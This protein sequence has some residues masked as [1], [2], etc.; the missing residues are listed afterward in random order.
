MSE[1]FAAP[2]RPTRPVRTVLTDLVNV[3]AR[4]RSV[5][6]QLAEVREGEE[7]RR[8]EQEVAAA[9]RA[10]VAADQAV[11]ED[12][13]RLQRMQ[14]D[15][16]KLRARRR[17]DIAGLKTVVDVERRRD[18]SHDLAVAERRLAEV[19]QAIE[20]EER[21]RRAAADSAGSA[22]GASR[23]LEQA[24][25]ALD[26]ARR[27]QESRERELS[28]QCDSLQ[29]HSTALR[30]DLPDPVLR[31]YERA[32]KENGV[33]AAVLSGAVCRACFM[34]LDR[35]SLTEVLEAPADAPAGCPECGT[36]LLP[37]TEG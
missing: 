6:A 4:W 28:G 33:G 21:A 18:L 30:A 24:L 12:E 1:F 27:R 11:A 31:R 23:A 10:R 14:Q 26:D 7:V 22:S 3:D 15:A 8:R 13:G 34:G 16:A 20:S 35:A 2:H 5:D 36:M 32:E 19:E 25:T 29:E 9:R 17:D 37:G